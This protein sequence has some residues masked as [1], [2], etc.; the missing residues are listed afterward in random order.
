MMSL[1]NRFSKSNDSIYSAKL[2][3][4]GSS[5]LVLPRI[6]GTVVRTSFPLQKFLLQLTY[7][8]LVT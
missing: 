5:A 3:E 6:C 7:Q 8:N 4:E 2:N 1:S